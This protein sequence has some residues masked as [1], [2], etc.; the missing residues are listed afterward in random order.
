MLA[1]A[2]S[3]Y[4]ANYYKGNSAYLDNSDHPNNL[5]ICC[6][7]QNSLGVTNSEDY[8]V[9]C[10][11]RMVSYYP[12]VPTDRCDLAALLGLSLLHK[13]VSNTV[14]NVL[15][16]AKSIHSPVWHSVSK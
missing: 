3:F 10:Y 14:Q 1:S 12:Y 7:G 15:R 6:C 4:L 2:V 13:T 9:C 11:L 5:V 8:Y 16:L